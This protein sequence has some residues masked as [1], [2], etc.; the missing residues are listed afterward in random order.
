MDLNK[1]K[2]PKRKLE[3]TSS[4]KLVCRKQMKPLQLEYNPVMLDQIESIGKS[5]REKKPFFHPQED[6]SAMQ[7]LNCPFQVCQIKDF[8]CNNERFLGDLQDELYNLKFK[9]RS[10]DLYHYNQSQDLRKPE[11]FNIG[12]FRQFMYSDFRK[13]LI[14]VTGFPLINTMDLTCSR[15]EHTDFL[16]CHDDQ[17]DSRKIAFIMYLC[18]NWQQTDGGAL[19]LFDTD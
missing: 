3:R 9:E 10:K 4:G 5:W 8:F 15:Y 6:G 14:N 17:C 12:Q 7:L 16:L 18:R 1:K 19:D 11:G 13:W 2:M